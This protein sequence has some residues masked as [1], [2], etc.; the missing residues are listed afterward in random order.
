[1]DA[2]APLEPF[3]RSVSDVAAPAVALIWQDPVP[4]VDH[5]LIDTADVVVSWRIRWN[6]D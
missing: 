2:F 4:A 1:M 5:A 6:D 3:T